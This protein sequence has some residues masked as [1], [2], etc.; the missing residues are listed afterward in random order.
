MRPQGVNIN[1]LV[2]PNIYYD[3]TNSGQQYEPP[4]GGQVNNGYAPNHNGSANQQ[5]AGNGKQVLP[6][7]PGPLNTQDVRFMEGNAGPQANE[8]STSQ[9]MPMECQNQQW[10][11]NAN[12]NTYQLRDVYGGIICEEPAMAVTTRAMRG[13]A[14]IEDE[15][16]G[17]E[18]HSS[19]NVERPQFQELGKVA[20]M[21]RQATRAV[22]RENEILDEEGGQPLVQDLK[23][24]DIDQWE[25]PKI[26]MDDVEAVKKPQ[27]KKTGGYD[28]WSDLSSLK[29]D[30][31]FGQLLEISPMARKTLK[32]GMPVNRYY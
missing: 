7:N 28:L 3:Q 21:A 11:P 18:N 20:S 23:D 19:D 9:S 12:M 29:A 14:P 32:E 25:G 10:S 6:H 27:V 26:P 2:Q 24:S 1:E 13:S 31:T 15:L 8:S 17:Q 5:P 16:D 30:I 22:A 4:A